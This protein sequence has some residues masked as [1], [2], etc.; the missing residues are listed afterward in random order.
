MKETSVGARIHGVLSSLELCCVLLLC[1]FVLT[2]LGTFY[3][4][5]HGLYA[6]KKR[7]FESLLLWHEVGGISI[8]VFPGGVACMLLLSV[9]MVLGGLLRARATARSI[10]VVIVHVGILFLLVAGLVKMISGEEGTLRLF[11]GQQSDYF[12]SEHHWEVA[13]WEI[14]GATRCRSTSSSTVSS[15]P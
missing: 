3:Q 2:I 10:G 15:T 12:E 1:L 9:N 8:P 13:I 5:D 14:G 11:E 4:I 6:A 7:Y